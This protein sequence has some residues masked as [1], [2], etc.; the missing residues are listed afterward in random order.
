VKV[1]DGAV[2]PYDGAVQISELTLR[3][4]N[5]KFPELDTFVYGASEWM[6]RPLDRWRFEEGITLA[7]QEL[8][9]L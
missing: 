8:L 9:H 2:A 1:V 6:D 3:V 5:E 7:A 4:P